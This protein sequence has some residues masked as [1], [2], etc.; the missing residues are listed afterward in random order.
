MVHLVEL[1]KG[2]R[3]NIGVIR[4][5]RIEILKLGAGVCLKEPAGVGELEELTDADLPAKS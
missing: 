1:V 3:R 2:L 5:N 4:N